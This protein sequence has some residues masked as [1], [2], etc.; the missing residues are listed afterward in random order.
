MKVSTLAKKSLIWL[1]IAFIAIVIWNSPGA[2]GG[3]L[4]DFLSDVKN[5]VGDLFERLGNFLDS[6]F[7]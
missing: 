4:S 3:A 2:S 7:E 5:F 1:G 6:F